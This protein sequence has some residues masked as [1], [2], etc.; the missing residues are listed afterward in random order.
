[1]AG[2]RRQNDIINRQEITGV[3][4]CSEIKRHNADR[5]SFQRKWHA[6]VSSDLLYSAG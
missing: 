1:M 5:H 2:L 3:Y 4:C 6:E